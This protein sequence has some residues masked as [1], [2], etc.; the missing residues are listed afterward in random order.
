MELREQL[1]TSGED[2]EPPESPYQVQLANEQSTLPI[3]ERLLTKVVR[4]VFQDSLYQSASVSLAMVDDPTMHRLNLEYLNHDYPTDVLSF[5][6]Q[7][8]GVHLEGQL[9]VSTDTAIENASQYGWSPN[10]EVLLYV[11]HGAL[12]L[13]GFDDQQPED[14]KAM[15]TAEALHLGNLGIRIP[16]SHR[17]ASEEQA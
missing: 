16:D 1:E 8:D 3:D 7:E 13:V 4:A 9:V 5:V 15:R 2:G 10:E 12:H 14:R 11:V 6:L 17:S